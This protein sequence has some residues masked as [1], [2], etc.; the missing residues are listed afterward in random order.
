LFGK[1][2][3]G[4][5]KFG[6]HC[7]RLIERKLNSSYNSQYGPSTIKVVGEAYERRDGQI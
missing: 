5:K 2:G 1:L 6:K 3:L 4:V 7:I